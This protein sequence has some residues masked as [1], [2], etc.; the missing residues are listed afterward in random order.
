MKCKILHE[1][2]GRIRVRIHK[3]KISFEEADRLEYYLLSFPGVTRVKVYERTCDA[4]VF[5]TGSRRDI[6]AALSAFSFESTAVDIPSGSSRALQAEYEERIVSLCVRQIIK[7][8]FFPS[9][10]RNAITVIKA[11]KYFIKGLRSLF[12]GRLDV[13][14]LDAVSITVSVLTGDFSTASSVMFLLS[15]GDTLEE[16]TRK[17]SIDDL[18][19]TMSLNIEKVW[20]KTDDGDVLVPVSE[21]EAGD[22]IVVRTGGMIPLDGRV[23]SGDVLI[24]QASM[25]GEP[26]PVRKSEGD[27][28]SRAP[29]LKRASA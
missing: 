15:L 17:K 28:V 11:A 20:L 12:K 27:A 16:W 14:V 5:Y 24:N 7:R 26:L 1:S 18:A 3:N 4:A 25:T 9:I 8:L 19:R 23:Y 13:A 2:S 21:I 6:I 22:R 10:L 29:L